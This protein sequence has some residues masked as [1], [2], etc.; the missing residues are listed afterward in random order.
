MKKLVQLIAFLLVITASNAQEQ[1]IETE[2]VSLENL[3]TFVLENV[4]ATNGNQNITFLLKTHE[5]DFSEEDKF[6]LKQT[7]ILLSKRLTNNDYISIVAYNHY[8]GIALKQSAAT[9]L[10]K[11]LYTI[12]YPKQS[13]KAFGDDGIDMAYSNAKENYKQGY[14]NKVI[15]VRLPK[16]KSN[17]LATPVAKQSLQNSKSGNGTAVVL[18]ALAL[19]PEIIAVIKN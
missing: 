15:M 11:M 9:E 14:Q 6:V 5:A 3:F 19:L 12:E 16:R 7:F 17:A 1:T 10:K 2:S 18:S 8:N 13:I 4:D